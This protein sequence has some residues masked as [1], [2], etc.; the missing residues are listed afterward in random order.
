MARKP[1]STEETE[2]EVL[3]EETPGTG[4]SSYAPRTPQLDQQ[5]QNWKAQR[6]VRCAHRT[7]DGYA[8]NCFHPLNLV[9]DKNRE[10]IPVK[11]EEGD[12]LQAECSW[13]KRH[14]LTDGAPQFILLEDLKPPEEQ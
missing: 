7:K 3:D 11:T 2:V 13:D 9:R 5:I 6:R 14:V 1:S 10:L 8:G 4:D 12:A